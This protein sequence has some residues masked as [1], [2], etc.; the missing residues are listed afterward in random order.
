M[1]IISEKETMEHL[2]T[3]TKKKHYVNN[4]MY[5]KSLTITNG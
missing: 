2:W 1:S 5:K 4:L 3:L